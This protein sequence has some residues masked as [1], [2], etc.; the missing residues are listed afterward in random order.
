MAPLVVNVTGGWNGHLDRRQFLL[1]SLGGAAAL[2][3]GS[4][5][6]AT[7]SQGAGRSVHLPQGATGFPSPFASNGDFGYSQTSLVYDSLVWKDGSGQLL[8]WLARSFTASTDHLTYTFELRDNLKW[9]DGQPLTADDVVFTFD[10]YAKQQTLPPPVIIQP[11]QG[12]AKVRAIGAQ[13]VEITLTSPLVTFAEQVAGALPIIPR[14]VWSSIKDPAS[15]Q[16]VKLLIGSGAYR[17]QSYSGDG[18][19]LLLV[20]RNDYYLGPPFVKRI[21]QRAIDDQ[22]SALLSGAAD[23][24]TGV[25]VR[26]DTLAPFDSN[27]SFG[28]ITDVGSSTNAMYWNLGKEGA[29]ADVRFR[30]AMLMAID[31]QDLVTRIAAG[32][33]RPGNPGFLSPNNP[34]FAP[35]PQYDFDVAGANSLLDAAGYRTPGGGGTRRDPKGIALSFEMIIDN[36]QAPLAEILVGQLKR[37]GVELR[38][39]EVQIGPQLFGNKLTGSYDIAVLPFPGPGPGGPNADPDILR[40]LFSSKLSPSLLAATAYANPAF[41]DLADKQ[42]VT[43]D[44]AGR[45]SMIAQMQMI[46]AQ[47]LAVVP[48]YYPETDRLYRK[49]VLDQWY[50]TPG[51]FP[52]LLDNKQLFITGSKT[53]TTIRAANG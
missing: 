35:V 12:I 32:R 41:D 42:L 28:K 4:C 52:A 34:F 8:P 49:S 25:G 13:T 31:R 36:A 50:F 51:Q 20:A 43:F 14:H 46:L 44:D 47:D 48:L 24:A 40:Q 38:P 45:K 37:I 18:G 39:K 11:P 6:G 1:A 16:D 21:E 10:Y 23:V 15:A 9:S 7:S 3:L 26:T 29:L 53:G 5:S 19:P 30:R 22:F 27:S 2:A 33:G 17:V